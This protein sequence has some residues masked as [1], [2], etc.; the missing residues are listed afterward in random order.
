M[1]GI[2]AISRAFGDIQFKDATTPSNSVIVATPDVHAEVITPMTEFAILGSD[3][4]WDSIDPQSAVNFV[5]KRIN[6]KMQFQSIVEELVE[7]ALNRG[8]V[9]NVT[10]T[11]LVFHLN[12]K[13]DSGNSLKSKDLVLV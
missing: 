2:I 3:G 4:L 8:S 12:R 10:A 1:N 5:R 11:V 7:E 13:G 9:D 6:R